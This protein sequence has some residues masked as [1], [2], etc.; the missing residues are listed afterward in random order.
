MSAL[1]RPRENRLKGKF[2]GLFDRLMGANHPNDERPGSSRL[3]FMI[4]SCADGILTRSRSMFTRAPEVTGEGTS[5]V[6]LQCANTFI[7]SYLLFS[8]IPECN[9]G[10]SQH[11][12][13]G[14]H[15]LCG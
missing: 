12:H 7:G 15:I 2:K 10:S 11:C 6:C 14:F 3:E 4:P 1:N 13:E 5:L 8:G 9:A